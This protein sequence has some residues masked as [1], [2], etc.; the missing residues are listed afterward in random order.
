MY[1]N[2]HVI[3]GS[4]SGDNSDSL[5]EFGITSINE[6]APTPG[7]AGGLSNLLNAIASGSKKGAVVV[8]PLINEGSVSLA[9][10]KPY[11]SFE[12]SG[13]VAS[14]PAVAPT[15]TITGTA[16]VASDPGEFAARLRRIAARG[17]E[18]ARPRY[19]PTCLDIWLAE[20]RNCKRN[21]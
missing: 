9:G 15:F 4:D 14:V 6:N 13:V 19:E 1:L 17:F 5:K 7:L 12:G 2:V 8:A 16:V 20:N 18:L 21:C 3:T 11:T 10:V